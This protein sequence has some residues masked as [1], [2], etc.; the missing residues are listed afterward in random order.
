MTSPSLLSRE[1]T[2]LS[3]RWP[4]NGHF[5]GV[6]PFL[7]VLLARRAS[8]VFQTADAQAIL[9]HEHDA[10][11]DHWHEGDGVR[12]DGRGDRAVVGRTK[13]RRHANT[14]GLVIAAD[15]SRCGHGNA[16]HEQCLQK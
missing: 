12:D 5:I 10:E 15:A 3:P 1:S 2:T 7:F 16:D 9:R 11:E 4:Q 6:S 8:K 14:I 13:K